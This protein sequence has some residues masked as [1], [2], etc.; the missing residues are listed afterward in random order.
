MT[1]NLSDI[2]L[3]NESLNLSDIKLDNESLKLIEIYKKKFPNNNILKRIPKNDWLRTQFSV[4][5]ILSSKPEKILN[6]GSGQGVFE[7]LLIL[8]NKNIKIRT[9]DIKNYELYFELSSNIEKKIKNIFQLNDEDKSEIVTCFQVLEHLPPEQLELAVNL[10]KKTARKK[11][12]ISVPFMEAP[13]YKGHFIY[14]D[15]NKIKSLFELANYTVLNK[16]KNNSWI[17]FEAKV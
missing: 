13:L 14:F 10:I 9:I 6:I 2:K 4:A 8:K 5:K 11:I 17:F 3:D 15:L 1:I 12:Y 7:N 16:N